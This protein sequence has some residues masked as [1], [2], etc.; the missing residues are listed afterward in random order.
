MGLSGHGLFAWVNPQKLLSLASSVGM[1]RELAPL[2]LVGANSIKNMAIGE[3]TSGGIS[4][5]KYVID[6]PVIGFRSYLPTIKTAPEFSLSGETKFITSFGL[7]SRTDFAAIENSIAV[8]ASSEMEEYYELKKQFSK[9]MGFDI[10]DIFDF[11][12]QDISYVSDEAGG[13]FALRLNDAEKFKA[14][15]EALLKV[16]KLKR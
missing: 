10:E 13:Y 5:L 7:P 14:T 3:G 2:S 4:R 9:T 8:F 6:M 16:Q 1:E 11:F 12:G 15:L